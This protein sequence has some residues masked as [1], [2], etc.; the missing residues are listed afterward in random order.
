MLSKCSLDAGS[1]AS[2]G[3]LLFFASYDVTRDSPYTLWQPVGRALL[4]AEKDGEPHQETAPPISRPHEQGVAAAEPAS[5]VIHVYGLCAGRGVTE[6]G[7]GGYGGENTRGR[8][9]GCGC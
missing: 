1:S 4:Y 8:G 9:S 5:S 3:S 6:A 7:C 2:V